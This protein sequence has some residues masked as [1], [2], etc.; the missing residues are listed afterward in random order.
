MHYDDKLYR[1]FDRFKFKMFEKEAVYKERRGPQ[2]YQLVLFG[3]HH[4]GH[5][6][7]RAFQQ[8]HKKYLVIDY[9]PDVI[10]MLDS[11]K[12][13]YLYGDATDVELLKEAGIE[14]SKLIVS[15]ISD[16]QTN[17][18]IIKMVE[19]MNPDVAIVCHADNIRE[20][21]A[22][23]EA[24]ASYVMIPHHIGSERMSAFI[25]KKGLDKEEFRKYRK[26]HLAYLEAHLGAPS[27]A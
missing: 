7:I 17:L 4:G 27:A 14:K 26:K 6:F 22:L 9:D 24:G 18:F 10:D 23:Y 11:Q 13:D 3:Y 21:T 20:A 16:H 15:T 5:E 2:A 12:I 1:Y 19:D 8:L 25:V